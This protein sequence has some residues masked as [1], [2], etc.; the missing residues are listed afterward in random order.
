MPIDQDPEIAD[1]VP[2]SDEVTS[3]DKAHFVTYLCLL[4]AS[5]EGMSE[6]EIARTVLRIDPKEEPLRAQEAVRSHLKRALWMTETGY[7]DLFEG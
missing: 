1:Q 5:G 6:D 4:D 2:W 3:Y 7:R